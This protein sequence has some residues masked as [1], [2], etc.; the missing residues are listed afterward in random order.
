[1][2]TEF[3]PTGPKE[4]GLRFNLVSF[5][6]TT[7][8]VLFVLAIVASGPPFRDPDLANILSSVGKLKASQLVVVSVFV[9]AFSF[10]A[11]P[12][13]LSLV[14][15]LEGYWGA[16]SARSSLG[17]LGIELNRRR[18]ERLYFDLYFAD[19]PVPSHVTRVAG[20]ILQGEDRAWREKAYRERQRQRADEQLDSFPSE[21]LLLPTRLGNALRAAE[22]LAGQRYG[23]DTLT[24]WPRLYAYLSERMEDVLA[25]LRDQLDIAARLCAVLVAA[26][27][28]S[29]ALL[30]VHGWWLL[31]PVVTALLAWV[32]YRAAVRAAISYGE[33]LYVAFDLHR[34]DMLRGLHLPLP[35]TP[36]EELEHNRA[37]SDF[38]A[39]L[40]SAST[41]PVER[42]DHSNDRPSRWR[43][44]NRLRFL[45]RSRSR[46][47]GAPSSSPLPP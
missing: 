26:T 21:E 19:L 42:Y 10:I 14:R 5:F 38:F 34:F 13:Q 7:L 30:A 28:V 33:Q 4:L 47:P 20:R 35:P 8:L 11:Y 27:L 23:L 17:A 31:V 45:K 40:R 25:D 44:A 37:L 41:L 15:L 46:P 9:L 16:S 29:V 12:F 32:A 18:R 39:E 6:P 43:L 36:A 1:V 3:S 24:M 2:A 22:D